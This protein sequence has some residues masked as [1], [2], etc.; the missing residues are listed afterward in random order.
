MIA[1]SV[2][3]TFESLFYLASEVKVHGTREMNDGSIVWVVQPSSMTH[4][5]FWAHRIEIPE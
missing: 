5:T 1:Y 2:P 3:L 4:T